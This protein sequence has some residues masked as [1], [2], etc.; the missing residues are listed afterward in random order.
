MTIRELYDWAAAHRLLDAPLRICDG[1]AVSFY[2]RPDD[3]KRG[4]YDA[5]IDVSACDPVEY[6]E[7]NAWAYVT[8]ND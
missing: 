6:D 7:L 4:R 1:M 5:V 8:L 2:P 3:L